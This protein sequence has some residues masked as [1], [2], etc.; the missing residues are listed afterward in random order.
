M[1]LLTPAQ[2]DG[3]WAWEDV[4]QGVI[5]TFDLARMRAVEPAQLDDS[6]FAQFLPATV[7]SVTVSGLLISANYALVNMDAAYV[8][9]LADG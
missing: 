6:A 8:R 5:D 2:W 3:T 9:T 4:L 1:L 7:A